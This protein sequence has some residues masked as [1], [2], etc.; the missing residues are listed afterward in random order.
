MKRP[1][2]RVALVSCV[3]KKHATPHPAGD[4]YTSP[5]FR[6]L[7]AYAQANAD[8]WFILSARHGL[9]HPSDVTEP[10]DTTLNTMRKAEREQWAS[11]VQDQLMHHLEP[12]SEVLLLAGARYREGVEGFLRDRGFHVSVPLERM[13]LG[14]QLRW[15]KQNLAGENVR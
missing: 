1:P 7:R 8:S 13:R 10:Y 5:L 3:K 11:R 4:L 2:R 15:L 9:I 6:G 12:G 14:E